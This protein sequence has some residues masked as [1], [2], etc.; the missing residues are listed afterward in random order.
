V[1]QK[2]PEEAV[3]KFTGFF[4]ESL[5]CVTTHGL[6]GK[7]TKRLQKVTFYPPAPVYTN[8]GAVLFIAVTHVFT[9]VPDKADGGYKVSSREYFYKL[10]DNP[11]ESEH[12]QGTFSYHWHPNG[13]PIRYPHLHL[14]ITPQLGYHGLEL[15]INRA[16]YPT[17]RVCVEDFVRLLIQGYDIKP[18]C[19]KSEWSRILQ[20]NK[21]AFHK[22]ATWSINAPSF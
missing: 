2:T 11:H 1:G 10:S 17:S 20:K 22:H 13:Y 4:S 15:R 6:I 9:T 5:S 12:D 19:A 7:R 16:H 21:T 14:T 8:T 18:T 3:E